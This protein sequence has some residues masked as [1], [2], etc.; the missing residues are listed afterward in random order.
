[1]KIAI[2]GKGGV[3]KTT[4]SA[5]IIQLISNKNQKVIALD[6]DLNM[7]LAAALGFPEEIQKKVLP[8]SSQNKL[9][10]ERT[11][12]KIKQY[13]QIFKLN[14]KVSD[15]VEKYATVFNSIALLVLGGVEKGGTGCA[16]PENT[17]IQALISDLIL[18]KNQA[19][20]IDMEAGVEHFGRATIRGVDT[21][22]IVVEPSNL[23][24]NVAKR[25]QKMAI[26]INF[27]PKSLK[28][29]G[30]KIIDE[31][32]KKFITD[33]FPDIDILGFI[34]YSKEIRSNDQKRSSVLKGLSQSMIEH[35]E[36][37]LSKIFNPISKN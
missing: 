5:A 3:G 16:C 27:N 31:L 26:D 21:V 36:Q 17:F 14:P 34:P 20:V 23:S 4:L 7:N 15:V 25:I 1:M 29:V 22:I 8:I 35:Y 18:Y 2:T 28:I 12:A 30:S 33:A 6:A 24:I 13:G 19:L 11:G 10:E 9:I 32:D 37:I